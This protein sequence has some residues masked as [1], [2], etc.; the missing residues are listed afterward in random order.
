M[1][2]DLTITSEQS[3]DIYNTIFTLT[4]FDWRLAD[5][6][7]IFIGIKF[8]LAILKFIDD[9]IKLPADT[10]VNNEVNVEGN[11]EERN[12]EQGVMA[13][14]RNFVPRFGQVIIA[15]FLVYSLSSVL[16]ILWVLSVHKFCIDLPLRMYTDNIYYSDDN[17]GHVLMEFLFT[18]T[19][20]MLHFI[21]GFWTIVPFCLYFTVDLRN[22]MLNGL[23]IRDSI[24]NS[25]LST[26][27]I[28][29]GIVHVPA[30]SYTLFKHRQESFDSIILE[31]N[32]AYIWCVALICF[33]AI[34]LITGGSKLLIKIN[35]QVKNERYVKGRAIENIDIPDEE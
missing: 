27:L 13:F 8:E 16:W 23:G 15:S 24:W 5:I 4:E 14:G 21:V 18:K 9:R 35:E 10:G 31:G 25:G 19:A 20:M 28:N 26:I 17:P 3:L 1:L 6:S 12:N 33:I 32:D 7:S 22:G 29:F 30:I 34:K 2:L 11:G